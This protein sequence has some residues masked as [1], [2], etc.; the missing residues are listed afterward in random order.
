M[1]MS[2]SIV[3][4]QPILLPALSSG[5]D[6]R[7]DGGDERPDD[8]VFEDVA[9]I[10]SY[11]PESLVGYAVKVW[12]PLDKEFYQGR[13]VSFNPATFMHKVGGPFGCCFK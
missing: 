11:A 3:L 2:S 7:P 9:D 4:I 8:V 12:W 1:A 6:E 5:G 13:V 10:A